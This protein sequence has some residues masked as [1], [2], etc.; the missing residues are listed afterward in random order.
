MRGRR[1][2]L[3]IVLALVAAMLSPRGSAGHPQQVNRTIP[4]VERW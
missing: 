3:V 2:Y 1:R 4:C